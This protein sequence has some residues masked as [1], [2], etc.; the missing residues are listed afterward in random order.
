MAQELEGRVI[1][2]DQSEGKEG[3][4]QGSVMSDA[5]E[6]QDRVVDRLRGKAWMGEILTIAGK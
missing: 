1:H 3:R 2:G 4:D 6:E 5:D